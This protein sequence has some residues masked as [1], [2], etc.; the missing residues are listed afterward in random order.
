MLSKT[1]VVYKM[2]IQ[3]RKPVLRF[4]VVSTRKIATHD[5]A[6]SLPDIP[7]I[8]VPTS[9]PGMAQATWKADC[10]PMKALGAIVDAEYS[11]YEDIDRLEELR[12]A[13]E[14]E[15]KSVAFNKMMSEFTGRAAEELEKTGCFKGPYPVHIAHAIIANN[16]YI[17]RTKLAAEKMKAATEAEI[18]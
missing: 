15:A 9:L 6:V 7:D 8:F 16:E 5:E 10:L 3:D 14:E 2:D 12:A 13:K 18:E 11:A 17:R 4:V 1:D